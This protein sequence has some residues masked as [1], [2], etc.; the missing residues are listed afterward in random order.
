M[1]HIYRFSICVYCF[2]RQILPLDIKNAAS[3]NKSS[4]KLIKNQYYF[5]TGIENS[6]PSL[7]PEGHRAVTVLVLV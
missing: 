2:C 4:V 3:V 7:I 6:P 1:I 5:M